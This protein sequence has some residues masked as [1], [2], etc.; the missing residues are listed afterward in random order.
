MTTLN[1]TASFSFFNLIFKKICSTHNSFLR[2]TPV[3]LFHVLHSYTQGFGAFLTGFRFKTASHLHQLTGEGQ[4]QHKISSLTV[5]LG[6][7]FVRERVISQRSLR[8]PVMFNVHRLTLRQQI[9]MQRNTS[10]VIAASRSGT[11]NAWLPAKRN[12]PGGCT[13]KPP[14]SGARNSD[15]LL[16]SSNDENSFN[17]MQCE[18]SDPS[19][20]FVL[21]T[22]RMKMSS[23]R[24]VQ[25]RCCIRKGYFFQKTLTPQS[26]QVT[27][28]GLALPSNHR[29]WNSSG[30][31]MWSIEAHTGLSVLI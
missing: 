16:L 3:F 17:S 25:W 18:P 26:Y 14:S 7:A 24:G 19:S 10:T 8:S 12:F 20:G 30:A 11:H 23:T 28:E 2:D 13:V 22:E 1:H 21:F 4:K 31:L 15:A 27:T 9:E 6:S 29:I 5:S